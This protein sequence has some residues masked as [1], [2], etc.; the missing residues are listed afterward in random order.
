[1]VKQGEKLEGMVISV[2]VQFATSDNSGAHI[3]IFSRMY[4]F[5]YVFDLL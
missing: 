4:K 3:Y 2:L 1:M 5:N